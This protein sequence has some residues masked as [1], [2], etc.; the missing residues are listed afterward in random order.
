MWAGHTVKACVMSSGRHRLWSRGRCP[1]TLTT[2]MRATVQ[3]PGLSCVQSARCCRQPRRLS[4]PSA[5]PPRDQIVFRHPLH[6]QCMCSGRCS[7]F[8]GLGEAAGCEDGMLFNNT[9]LG[10][11]CPWW[12]RRCGL[13]PPPSSPWF[14]GCRHRD[15]TQFAAILPQLQRQRHW[16][17]QGPR[18]FMV[19]RAWWAISRRSVLIRSITRKSPCRRCPCA[20]GHLCTIT[21]S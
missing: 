5:S 14:A 2:R 8:A 15:I 16:R 20:F 3:G 10:C 4:Q 1:C 21:S 19:R 13:Q 12:D 9:P 17:R 7:L 18:R 11:I 6:K